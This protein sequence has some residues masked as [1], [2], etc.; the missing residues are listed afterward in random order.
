MKWASTP[1]HSLVPKLDVPRIPSKA[2]G[3]AK[4]KGRNETEMTRD[5]MLAI[6]DAMP[7]A[8]A[9]AIRRTTLLAGCRASGSARNR[10]EAR[11]PEHWQP[12]AEELT[13]TA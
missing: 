13:I 5:E 7:N 11:R 4:L 9:P 3:T 6:V 8:P 1:G 2:K 10:A 12:G